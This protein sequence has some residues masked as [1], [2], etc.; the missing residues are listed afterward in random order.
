VQNKA[1]KVIVGP[2]PEPVRSA[3]QKSCKGLGSNAKAIAQANARKLNTKTWFAILIF[4][5]INSNV[6]VKE[7]I[8][9]NY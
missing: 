7:D 8:K 3:M 2:Q 1:K 4:V 5:S 6:K 9:L